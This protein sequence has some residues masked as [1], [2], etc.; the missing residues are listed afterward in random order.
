MMGKW[1]C[2]WSLTLSHL[3]WKEDE[4]LFFMVEPFKIVGEIRLLESGESR[5]KH[6]SISG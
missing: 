2:F 5:I 4:E 1:I 6:G 3:N